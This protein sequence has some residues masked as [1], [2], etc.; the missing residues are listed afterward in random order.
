MVSH[1]SSDGFGLKAGN[2]MVKENSG[3][4]MGSSLLD[5]K[6]PEMS[7]TVTHAPSTGFHE[8][9]LIDQMISDVFMITA[10]PKAANQHLSGSTGKTF[11]YEFCN[12]GQRFSLDQIDLIGAVGVY[13]SE[14][15]LTEWR[16]DMVIKI[17][18]PK[19]GLEWVEV[20]ANHRDFAVVWKKKNES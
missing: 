3:I 7:K 8:E 19:F 11:L 6:I 10:D 9:K 1:T 20:Y 5:E 17:S 16:A 13:D 14:V 15:H 18:V 2:T 4:P 12:G